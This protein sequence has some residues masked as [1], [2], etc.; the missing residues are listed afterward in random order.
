MGYGRDLKDVT[1]FTTLAIWALVICI[2]VGGAFYFGWL[3]YGKK[4]SLDLKREAIKHSIQYTES[5]RAEVNLLI[6][7]YNKAK[8]DYTKYKAANEDGKYDQVIVNLKIQ[9]GSIRNQIKDRISH[10]PESEIP[11]NVRLIIGGG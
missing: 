10:M 1:K 9:I 3:K 6:T 5:I 4:A 7:S 11:S 2:V 8:T